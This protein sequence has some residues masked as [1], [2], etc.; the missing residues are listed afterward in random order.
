MSLIL[1]DVIGAVVDVVDV[2]ECGWPKLYYS[3]TTI[4][5]LTQAAPRAMCFTLC[6]SRYVFHDNGEWSSDVDDV[7]AGV[8][9]GVGD[10]REC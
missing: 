2:V 7:G 3:A 5:A 10:A 6:V 1:S 8:G 4:P 9:A